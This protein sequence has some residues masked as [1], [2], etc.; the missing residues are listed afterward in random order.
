MSFAD[1]MGTEPPVHF[2]CSR[3]YFL[4]VFFLPPFPSSLSPPSFSTS[5]C[6]DT[7]Q[8]DALYHSI[9]C[10]NAR[11]TSIFSN[12]ILPWLIYNSPTIH[13]LCTLYDYASLPDAACKN[14]FFA[15]LANRRL[16]FSAC[17]GNNDDGNTVQR[18]YANHSQEYNIRKDSFWEIQR[19]KGGGRQSWNHRKK[20]LGGIR[21]NIL[22]HFNV[23][24]GATIMEPQRNDSNVRRRLRGGYGSFGLGRQ[25]MGRTA[26][27]GW[28]IWWQGM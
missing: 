16:V 13:R 22:Q 24:G 23:G 9:L 5:G 28:K 25:L 15:T 1:I 6:L 7:C 11:L 8:S 20:V 4:H 14:I 3:L 19:K 26:H 21:Y 17:Q 2:C 27:V 18:T 12:H 10:L